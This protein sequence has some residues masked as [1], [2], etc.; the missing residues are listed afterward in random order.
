[1]SRR[2]LALVP[3]LLALVFA[4]AC[5][6]G[7]GGPAKKA[8]FDAAQTL[9]QAAQAMG[10]LKSVAFTLESEGKIP[11]MVKGGDMKLLRSGDAEGTLAVEQ[12]GQ[13]VEMKVVAVG[14][15]IYLDAGTG[16]WRKLPKGLAASVYDPSAVLDPER[17]IAKLLT[18]AREPSPEAV[19][20]VDGKEAYRMAAKLPKD[21]VAGLIPGIGEDMDGQVWVSKADHRLLKVRGA[22]PKDAG[23]VTIKFTEFD[24][25]YKISA[26]R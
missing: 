4:G 10:G 2:I 16:G 11:V 26:P 15:S 6:G 17:G 1:M 9:R 22:F 3:V 14:D 5:D 8:D 21:Q 20:K 12:Q 25:P 24:A 23:A 19:E 18:S 7:S 13:K